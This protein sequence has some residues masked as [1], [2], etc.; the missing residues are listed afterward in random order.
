MI[1]TTTIRLNDRVKKAAHEKA[2][3]HLIRGGFSVYVENLIRADLK[4]DG[5]TF[6]A[7]EK[8]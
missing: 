3:N 1:T 6:N 7:E 8:K 5:L 2:K 4:K